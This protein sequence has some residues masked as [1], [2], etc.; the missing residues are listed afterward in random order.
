MRSPVR[1]RV[2]APDTP[3]DYLGA[4]VFL[5]LRYFGANLRFL[6]CFS[7]LK[8][9]LKERTFSLKISSP[10]AFFVFRGCPGDAPRPIWSGFAEHTARQGLKAEGAESKAFS[11]IGE[12]RVATFAK[13]EHLGINSRVNY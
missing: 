5:G 7:F 3:E 13:G 1:I 9:A 8:L 4:M 12:I 10:Y 2:A 6:A 11:L